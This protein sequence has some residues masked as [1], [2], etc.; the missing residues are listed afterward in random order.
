MSH[1][2]IKH[3]VSLGGQENSTIIWTPVSICVL[4]QREAKRMRWLQHKAI[5]ATRSKKKRNCMAQAGIQSYGLG[6]P[7]ETSSWV[8]CYMSRKLMNL[9]TVDQFVKRL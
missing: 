8:E 3:V 4:W 1:D 2:A 5:L 7:K 6:S 9:V